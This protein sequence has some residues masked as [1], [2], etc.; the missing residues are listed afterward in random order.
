LSGQAVQPAT[1]IIALVCSTSSLVV[2]KVSISKASP[3]V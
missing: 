3:Q 1:I 2:D